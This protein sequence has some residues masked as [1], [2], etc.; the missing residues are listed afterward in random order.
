[1]SD[2]AH[3]N[4]TE[5]EISPSSIPIIPGSYQQLVAQEEEEQR[6]RGSDHDDDENII[7][8]PSNHAGRL[9][10]RRTFANFVLMS[11][12]FSANHGCVVG[13]YSQ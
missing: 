12:L 7:I 8:L 9:A 10:A 1:M 11:I 6:R 13:E 2:Q 4:N 3:Q 5:T